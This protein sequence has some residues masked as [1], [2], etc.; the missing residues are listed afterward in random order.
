[1][2]VFVEDGIKAYYT[3]MNALKENNPPFKG[4]EETKGE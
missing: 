1:M 3:V 2:I 4:E